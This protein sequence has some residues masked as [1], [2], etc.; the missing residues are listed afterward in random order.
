[1]KRPWDGS[2]DVLRTGAAVLVVLLHCSGSLRP[3]AEFGPEWWGTALLQAFTRSAV[4]LFVMISGALL[5]GPETENLAAFYRRRASRI[6]VPLIFWMLFYQLIST[7]GLSGR[8]VATIYGGTPYPHLWYLYMLLCLYFVLPAVSAA[9]RSMNRGWLVLLSLGLIGSTFLSY[10]YNLLV[11]H[12][13]PVLFF[14]LKTIPFIGYALIGKVLYDAL[15]RRSGWPARYASRHTR[16][17]PRHA[18]AQPDSA[19]MRSGRLRP[20]RW[21]CSSRPRFSVRCSCFPR[22]DGSD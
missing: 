7:R 6:L 11:F 3:L 14:P 5:I 18:G 21:S 1:M 12:R 2:L 13:F 10:A 20:A 4:P 22:R 16:R 9:Y 15:P 19:V 8:I 17:W